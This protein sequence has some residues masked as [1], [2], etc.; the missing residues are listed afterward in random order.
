MMILQVDKPSF[1]FKKKG[2]TFVIEAKNIVGKYVSYQGR[3]L[4]RQDK[5]LFYGDLADPYHVY[6]LIMSEKDSG[7]ADVKIPEKVLVQLLHSEDGKL[8]RQSTANDLSE[9]FEMAV[10][11]LNRYNRE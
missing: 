2:E 10:A 1:E 9:A 5:E 4:V 7:K 6:M 11:W 8:E 3:P